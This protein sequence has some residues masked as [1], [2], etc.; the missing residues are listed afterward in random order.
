LD[1]QVAGFVASKSEFL[2]IR[3][4]KVKLMLYLGIQVHHLKRKDAKDVATRAFNRTHYF[5]FHY[6]FFCNLS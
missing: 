6:F 3:A 5:K 1:A 4:F 2:K